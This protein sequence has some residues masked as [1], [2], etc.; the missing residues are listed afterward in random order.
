MEIQTFVSVCM[1]TR[2]LYTHTHTQIYTE[3]NHYEPKGT[4]FLGRYAVSNWVIEIHWET[5]SILNH[6]FVKKVQRIWWRNVNK[7]W[8]GQGR[9][10]FSL[11]NLGTGNVKIFSLTIFSQLFNSNDKGIEK[12]RKWQRRMRI[13]NIIFANILVSPLTLEMSVCTKCEGTTDTCFFSLFCVNLTRLGS[14]FCKVLSFGPWCV[15]PLLECTKS[16]N[17]EL[18]GEKSVTDQ[19]DQY[20]IYI[21]LPKT[22]VFLQKFSELVNAK[23]NLP[24]TSRHSC[25]GLS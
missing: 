15:L 20:K 2:W 24:C 25:H 13:Q 22:K 9:G 4:L 11:R 17:A 5:S 21:C 8:I 18:T 7:I 10:P 12:G 19:V 23:K 1:H 16:T 3:P 6:Q 14:W